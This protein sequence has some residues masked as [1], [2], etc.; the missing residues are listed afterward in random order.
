MNFCKNCGTV[1]PNGQTQCPNCGTP[2]E[3]TTQQKFSEV[4]SELKSTAVNMLD[5]CEDHTDEFDVNDVQQNRGIAVISYVSWLCLI[6]IIKGTTP[7]TKFHA[8]QGLTLAVLGTG[9]SIVLGLLRLL[10]GGIFPLGTIVR[11]LS[12][13]VR[14]IL[15]LYMILGIVNAVNDK[16]KELPFIGKINLLK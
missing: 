10:L 2:L 8:N 3:M 13:I 14:A 12:F 9:V 11:I 1:I 5:A 6:P 15:A 16:A 7:Y 4:G